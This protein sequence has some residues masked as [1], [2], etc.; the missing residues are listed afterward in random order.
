VTES[1]RAAFPNT[2]VL[3][4]SGNHETNIV[5]MYPPPQIHDKFPL[6]W[7]YSAISD[8]FVKHMGDPGQVGAFKRGGFYTVSP[9]TG[10]RFIIL[11]TNLCYIQN[12]WLPFDPMDP[13]G[14]LQW[15]SNELAKAEAA[16]ENVY[17]IAH[18]PPGSDA[19]WAHW[20]DQYD[21]IINR[22]AHIIRF[23]MFGHVH[24]EFYIVSFDRA[25]TGQFE[26]S[27][28]KLT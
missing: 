4:L 24:S 28:R 11:N 8:P 13:A 21:R 7:M 19:C 23:Q 26:L 27:F 20:S 2:A 6:D 17:V 15:F 25:A 3:P 18:I 10:L 12:F 14:Q 1:L 5:N 22:Y 9:Q 16:N